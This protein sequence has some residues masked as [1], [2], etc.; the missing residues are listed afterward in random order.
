MERHASYVEQA[1]DYYREQRWKQ[2]LLAARVPRGLVVR[3]GTLAGLGGASAVAQI[4]AAC[5]AGGTSKETVIGT[6]AEGAYQY[7]KYA[8]IEKYNCRSLAWGGTPCVDGT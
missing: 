7:S 3:A 6:S 2:R 1:Y 8:Y 5:A 4:L